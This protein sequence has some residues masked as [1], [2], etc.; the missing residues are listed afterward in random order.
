MKEKMLTKL[1]RDRVL[2]EVQGLKSVL[3]SKE[4]TQVSNGMCHQ[5]SLPGAS[6]TAIFVQS[7]FLAIMLIIVTSA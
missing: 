1:E 3:S 2:G 6:A 5:D 4:P 7:T